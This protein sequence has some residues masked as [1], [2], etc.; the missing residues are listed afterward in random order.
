MAWEDE[1]DCL[2]QMRKWMITSAIATE[3]EMDELEATAKKYVRD[4][5][6]QVWNELSDEIRLELNEAARLIEKLAEYVPVREELLAIVSELREC[7]DPGRKDVFAAIRKTL[8]LTIKENVLQK[9]QLINWLEEE[10]V[11]NKARFNSK[12]FT[13][14]LH[15]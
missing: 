2:L 14:T 3:A 13:R 10:K 1:H 11:K 8:R 9:Q 6:R 15:S 5:Q 12:L 7:V 4:C